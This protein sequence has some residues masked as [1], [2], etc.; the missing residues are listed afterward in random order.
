M[1]GHAAE[2]DRS[3]PGDRPPIAYV[4]SRWP[5][6]TET[7]ILYEVLAIEALGQRVELFPLLRHREPLSHPEALELA[8]R[9][10]Y[11]P[12]LSRAIMASQI[13]AIRRRPRSYF[14]ALAVLVRGTLGSAN[15]LFGG[16]A[17][18]PKVV[19]MARQMEEAGVSHVHCHFSNHP[20]A[21]GFIIHRL[22]GIPYSF[23]A[24]GSDLHVD[25]HMLDR[26]VAEAA[27][28]VAISADNKE[29]IVEEVGD[30]A[31]ARIDV[32]H[33]GVDTARLRPRSDPRRVD[34]TFTILCIGTLHEVKGQQVLV[35]A[36]RLLRDRG[37]ALRCRLIGDGEDEGLL[38]ERIAAAGLDGIVSLDGRRTRDEVI[39]AIGE[40]DLLVTP[41]VVARNGKREGI[42]VV[43][44]EA[45][46]CGLPVVA[47]RLSGIPELVE[48]E[49][50]GL[51]VQPG[52]PGALADAI[53][54]L[55]RDAELRARMGAAAR[56]RIEREFDLATNARTILD[57]IAAAGAAPESA[58]LTVG[59]DTPA[60]GRLTVE[61]IIGH[62]R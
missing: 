15:Y 39:A 38:R 24:H 31:R 50:E 26:K 13:D 41:S 2:Q 17:I 42:P 57:R 62:R 6:L 40:A 32:I 58:T 8:A 1:A 34:R 11:L 10:H 12:F 48:H 61:P 28:V 43:L 59:R 19:H 3:S 27:F 37:V 25:R 60:D 16:L 54:R 56:R 14:G 45:M 49:I 20:A 9:A 44:M 51:L 29:E 46:S 4:M 21:A 5:K 36:C 18:F 52:E 53:E 55:Y 47:S 35:E 23:V 33:C 30:W 22:T 7:F